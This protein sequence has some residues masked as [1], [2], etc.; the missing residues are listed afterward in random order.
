MEKENEFEKMY[1][2]DEAFN[3]DDE[4]DSSENNNEEQEDLVASGSSGLEYDFTKAPSTTKGPERID[5]D[6]KT[7][8]I[9]DAKLILPKPE[10][11]WSLSKNKK[12]KYKPCMFVLYYDNDGQ[13]EYYSGVKVF[14]REE[15]GLIKYSDPII[16]NEAENQATE[17]KKVYSKF[18]G[19]TPEEVSM[20]EF[21]MYLKTKPKA[22]IQSKTFKYDG[23][24]TNKNIVV[25]F[26]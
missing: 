25:K 9:T 21:L 18:K 2:A 11:E 14:Q 1:N 23:K 12:V 16:H 3:S 8:T 24:E 10:T 17:L 5:L 26:V 6:G 7:V 15:K 4:F 19:K 13:R 22:V 20:R